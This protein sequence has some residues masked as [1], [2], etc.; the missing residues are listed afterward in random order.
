MPVPFAFPF[1]RR[2][3]IKAV[4]RASG[5]SPALPAGIR[6]FTRGGIGSVHEIPNAIER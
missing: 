2:T 6:V 4:I 3:G 1:D 5:S